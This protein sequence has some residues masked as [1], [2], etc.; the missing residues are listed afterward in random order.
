MALLCSPGCLELTEIRLWLWILGLQQGTEHLNKEDGLKSYY[1]Q[2]N[3]YSQEIEFLK[4]R[5]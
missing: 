4:N 3:F 1:L 5:F 2:V